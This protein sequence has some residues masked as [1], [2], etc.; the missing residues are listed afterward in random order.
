[1]DRSGELFE[2][3]INTT[4]RDSETTPGLDSEVESSSALS[5]VSRTTNRQVSSIHQH[6]RPASKEEKTRTKKL[7]FCRYCDPTNF[8][9]Y[10]ASS[11]GLRGH[12]K[13]E[14]EIIWSPDE[15]ATRTTVKDEGA[16]A[17]EDLYKKL[18]AKGELEGLEGEVLK[19]SI[20]QE[21]VKESLL[22]LI[23]INRLPFTIVEWPEFHAFITA[24]NREAMKTLF[25]PTT[26]KTISNWISARF[27]NSLALVRKVLRTAKT[28]IHL[29]VD[30][31]TS[32]SHALLLGICTSFVDSYNQ[33]R[34][35]LIALRTVNSQSGEDQ[36]NTLRPVLQ[37]FEIETKI[38]ALI[39][40][41]AG[42]NDVLCRTISEWLFLTHR[43]QWNPVHQRMRCL[44]HI[45]NLVV[46]AFLFPSKKDLK[47]MEL[48]DKE[49]EKLLENNDDDDEEE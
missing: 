1:M 37:E 30:I 32:P 9:G 12:L 48:Y 35:P 22:N 44:G 11:T 29:A 17:T 21:S 2:F 26:H 42:S 13:S 23:L 27:D 49:D 47:Q 20:H 46:S 16:Q 8:K 34:N 25:I 43:I 5:V 4:S 40:D 15:N 36:W 33:Y 3:E 39:G 14:H 41:N 38:G 28:P 10:H 24:V 45:I 6:T 31:W 7:Y 18:L 19:R